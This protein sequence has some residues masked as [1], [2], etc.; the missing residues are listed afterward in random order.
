MPNFP[1]ALMN[2]ETKVKETVKNQQ[3]YKFSEHLV[4]VS[5]FQWNNDL[6]LSRRMVV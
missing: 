1:V 3:L 2:A 5:V 4:M 6:N